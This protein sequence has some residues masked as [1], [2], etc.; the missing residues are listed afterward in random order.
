[1][2]ERSAIGHRMARTNP[3]GIEFLSDGQAEPV[4]SAGQAGAAD[5]GDV[6]WRG[7]AQAA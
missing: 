3:A 4:G 6:L 1:M 5:S 7:Q 2:T